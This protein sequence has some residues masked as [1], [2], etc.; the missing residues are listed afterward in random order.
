MQ[1]FPA[2]VSLIAVMPF[3]TALIAVMP[4]LTLGGIPQGILYSR[5]HSVSLLNAPRS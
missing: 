2:A 1:H 5:A 4:F 3:F